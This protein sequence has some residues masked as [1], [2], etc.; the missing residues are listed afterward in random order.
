MLI[1]VIYILFAPALFFLAYKFDIDPFNIKSQ[2]VTKV[3]DKYGKRPSLNFSFSESIEK[4]ML[5]QEEL[6][7]LKYEQD[8]KNE[9]KNKINELE[10]EIEDLKEEL[11]I[12][13]SERKINNSIQFFCGFT[14][15]CPPA[16]YESRKKALGLK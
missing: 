15:V 8:E 5:K 1:V 14:G 16:Y 7:K 2:L 12:E 3:T 6:N 9:M 13:N 11:K 10:L 4:E